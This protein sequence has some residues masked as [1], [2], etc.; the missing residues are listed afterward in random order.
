MVVGLTQ[1]WDLRELLVYQGPKFLAGPGE[2][3]P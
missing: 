2:T 1:S 3:K